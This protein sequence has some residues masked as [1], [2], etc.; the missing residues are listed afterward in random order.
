MIISKKKRVALKRVLWAFIPAVLVLCLGVVALDFYAMHRISH[1]QRTQL[2]GSPRDFQVILQKPMWS[3]EKWKN[4]DSTESVG[5]FLSQGRPA[6]SLVLSHGYGSNRSELLTLSFE[7]W[8]AGFHVLVYD[9]RGHGESPVNWSGLG[10]YETDDVLSAIKFLKS[11]KNDKGQELFDGRVG[12]YGVD[13]GAYVSLAASAQDPSIKAVAVDSVYPDVDQYLNYRM[14]ALLGSNDWANGLL[15]SSLANNM[16]EI[17]M[18]LYLLRREDTA[19]AVEAVAASSGKRFLFI[20]GKDAGKLNEMTREVQAQ[21]K[22]QSELIEMDQTRIQRLYDEA[23]STYDARVV[24]F[25]G[26]AMPV[27]N[28]KPGVAKKTKK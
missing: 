1:P 8:K 28:E 25:F 18:Q 13:I 27:M 26:T 6:P 12:L 5:W 22:D 9:L 10:T 14:K 23:S 24:A 15:D 17:V 2:Y 19:P 20:A 16:N 4:T 3:D 7:L 21:T 11:Q